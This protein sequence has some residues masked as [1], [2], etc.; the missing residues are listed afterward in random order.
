MKLLRNSKAVKALHELINKCASKDNA[1]NT[2]RVLR[3]IGKH[4]A[5]TGREMR[6]T[7][8]IGDYEMDQVILDLGYD[9]NVLPT[10]T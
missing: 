10:Q 9:A 8:Q 7:A 6:L 3:M 4:K 1:P 2:P 5:R